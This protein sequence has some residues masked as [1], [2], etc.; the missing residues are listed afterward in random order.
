MRKLPDRPFNK[1]QLL[2]ELAAL[3]LP[4]FTGFARLS[5]EIDE[6][7]RAVIENG[8]VKKVPPYILI[9]SAAL[10]G[11]QIAA[12]TRAVADHVPVVDPPPDPR[13]EEQAKVIEADSVLDPA[14]KAAL[15]TLARAL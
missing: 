8:A 2:G 7:G 9:K 3:D 11:P 6:Q 5:R 14:T 13:F 15:V 4:G 10:S 1:R 12:A